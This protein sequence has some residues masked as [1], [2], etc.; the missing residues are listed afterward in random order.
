VPC[1][2]TGAKHCR[3]PRLRG[4]CS[5]WPITPNYYGQRASINQ[6]LSAH[7][8]V[9]VL[10]QSDN[11]CLSIQERRLSGLSG[12]LHGWQR[13]FGLDMPRV[14]TFKVGCPE[15]RF[16][17]SAADQEAQSAHRTQVTNDRT[18]SRDS[19]DL[20][21]EQENQLAYQQYNTVKSKPDLSES[22][23]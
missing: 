14:A 8:I 7:A 1:N 11:P 20:R 18:G 4:I 21:K 3:I 2:T 10:T 9:S 22:E 13:E 17:G 12:V 15:W 5:Q 16:L 19:R 6:R 23:V